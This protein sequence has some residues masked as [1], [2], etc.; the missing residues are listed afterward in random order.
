MKAALLLCLSL[1]VAAQ[2]LAPRRP[3]LSE[4]LS[5]ASTDER[6]KTCEKLLAATPGVLK[7][8]IE[9][10]SAYLQ[11]LRESAD[12]T[13]LDR[14][15][16]LVNQ[17]LEADG[18][19]LVAM[20]FQNEIDLQRHDFQGVAERAQDMLKYAPSDAGSWANLG[21]ALMEL[22]EY[23][24]AEAAYLRMFSLRPGLASYNRLAW[25]RFVTGDPETAISLMREAVAAG[26]P[27]P[28]NTAWCLAELGDMY[29]KTGKLS[30][31]R[32]AYASALDTFPTLHRALAGMGRVNA[33]QDH[34]E[35]AIQNY[36]RAQ[37]IVPLPDYAAALEDLYS[38]AG[39][40]RKA[41]EQRALIATIEKLGQAN[42]ER[43]NRNLALLLADHD[44]DLN[45]ALTL[46]E[47]ELPLRGD[48]YTW[49]AYSWILFKLHRLS[50]AQAASVKALRLGTPEPV[51]YYHAEQIAK[52]LGDEKATY[53]YSAQLAALNPNFDVARTVSR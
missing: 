12:F 10:T 35:E 22:G 42:K 17:M 24:R 52:A 32:S 2:S 1:T 9:L 15:S 28:E 36:L 29:F 43:L 44:R 50:D 49:D 33:A 40:T 30:E 26:D 19:S 51:F 7:L 38:A 31:A 3:V 18:G 6:I 53:Q 4:Q 21:D 34:S 47:T 11:K 45:V 48:V 23:P 39:Q 13:Y 8:Q 25:Y 20:R 5:H 46:I 16:K 14:A 37:S 41:N 27:A